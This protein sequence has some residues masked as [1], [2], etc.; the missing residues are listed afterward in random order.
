[1]AFLQQDD[2]QLHYQ[3]FGDVAKPAII[4]SNSLGTTYHMW[5]TQIDAL[6][7]DYF[8]ICYDTRG[9]GQSDIF[10]PNYTLAQLGQD[11]LAILDE[12]NIEQAYFCGISMGGIT[13][14]WLAIFAPQR[15]KAIMV[16]NTASKIGQAQAWL[17]RANLV[18]A[19]GLQPIAD[20][21]PSRWFTED[22]IQNQAEQVAKLSQGLANGNA[23]GYARCCE[24]LADA[25]VRADLANIQVPL[26]VVAGTQD[27]VTT[28]ADAEAICQQVTH[29]HL[30]RID[31]SHISNVEQAEHF[32]RLIRQYFILN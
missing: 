14:Q 26:I 24:A 12:L 7:N 5:Q 8:I 9:H 4:F 1:M 20:T 23:E 16:A 29:A 32:N 6:Q 17:D 28:V 11:V 19:Q 13:G 27:P 10:Q 15:F 18:R 25:D 31:A 2:G 21:A 30:E 3:T 22:F